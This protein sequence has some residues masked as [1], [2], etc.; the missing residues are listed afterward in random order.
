MP[1]AHEKSTLELF[2]ELHEITATLML[3]L[4]ALHVGAALKHQLIDKDGTM[5][6]MVPWLK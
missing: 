1:I 2:H 6:R 4:L 3:V 5:R